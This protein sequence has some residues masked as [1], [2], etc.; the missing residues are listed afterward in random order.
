VAKQ[1][2]V[3]PLP[4][5]VR[6]MRAVV[7]RTNTSLSLLQAAFWAALIAIPLIVV[8]RARRR[9]AHHPLAGPG[10]DKPPGYE[11]P[12]PLDTTGHDVRTALQ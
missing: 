10:D 8:L 1:M 7:V 4:A 5:R 2:K 9:R 11:N 12:T 3:R 6:E